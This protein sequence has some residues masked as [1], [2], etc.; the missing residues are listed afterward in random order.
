MISR[1]SFTVTVTS[2]KFTEETEVSAVNFILSWLLLRYFTKSS[3][4]SWP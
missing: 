3:K 2:R 4:A 1:L